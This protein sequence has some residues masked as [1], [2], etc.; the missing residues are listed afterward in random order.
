MPRWNAW[1]WI[2][3]LVRNFRTLSP[4]ER[5]A[6]LIASYVLADQGSHWRQHIARELSPFENLVKI[7]ASEKAQINSWRIPL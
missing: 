6:F 4:V 5:R 2:S 7:W 1:Y 3:D